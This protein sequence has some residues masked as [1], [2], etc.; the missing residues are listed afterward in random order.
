MNDKEIARRMG[1]ILLLHAEVT[2][3]AYK[4]RQ[5]SKGRDPTQEEAAKGMTVC[6]RPMTDEEKL[7][8]SMETMKRHVNALNEL[9]DSSY[10]E[11]D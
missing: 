3:G 8:D 2:S 5:V 11:E 9:V 4:L 10:R 1:Y 6:W 7:H